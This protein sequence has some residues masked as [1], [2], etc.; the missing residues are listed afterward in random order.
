M[1]QHSSPP[2]QTIPATRRYRVTNWP[3]YNRALVSRGAVTLWLHEEVLRGWRA[4]GGKGKRHG[5][6]AIRCGLSLRAI[7][8][9]PLRQTQGFLR[10]LTVL[11]GLTIP[12]PHYATL[13]RR[14]Q[15]LVVPPLPRGAR[16]GPVHL[17]ID[18]PRSDLAGSS[19]LA[20]GSG[21]CASMARENAACGASCIWR[22]IP[23]Q[24]R[25]RPTA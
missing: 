11:L 19:F 7:F 16:D 1:A 22:W 17:A 9:L 2:A 24:P 18:S 21:G 3:D 23:R 25:F 12:V 13:S 6:A 5:D 20:R 10:S 15:D 14:A 4:T 8:K